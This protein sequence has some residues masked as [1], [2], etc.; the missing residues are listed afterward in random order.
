V[1]QQILYCGACQTQLR[2]SDFEK[3]GAVK[4]GLEA[5]CKACVPADRAAAL[6]ASSPKSPAPPTETPKRGSQRIPL[7][8]SRTPRPR[9]STVAVPVSRP[10][11]AALWAAAAGG[12]VVIL[13]VAVL[14]SGSSP[15]KPAPPKPGLVRVDPEPPPPPP[16]SGPTLREQKALESLKA[17]R[18]AAREDAFVKAVNDALG[19]P[20]EADARRGLEELRAERRRAADA[21]AVEAETKL[22]AVLDAEDFKRAAELAPARA[23]EFLARAELLFRPL[24]DKALDAFRRGATE[25]VDKARAR[26]AAWGLGTFAADLDRAVAEASKPPPPPPPADAPPSAEAVKA[27]RDAAFER[28]AGRVFPEALEALARLKSPEAAEDLDLLRLVA[29]AHD[30]ALKALAK[31]PKGKKLA[32]TTT[33]YDREISR[34]EATFVRVHDFHLELLRGKSPMTVQLGMT[35]PRTFAEILPAKDR[36]AVAAA[37][38]LEGDEAGALEILKDDRAP[39]P[40]RWWD[41][42]ADFRRRHAEGPLASLERDVSYRFYEAMLRFPSPARRADGALLCAKIAREHRD[43]PWVGRHLPL[44]ESRAELAREF[45]AGP[46]VLRA[47]GAFR[48]ETDR[49]RAYWMSTADGD[50]AR[51]ASV[52]EADFS[53][54]PDVAYRAWAWIGACCAETAAFTLSG[55]DFP[56]GDEAPP[57]KTGFLSSTKTH[58]GHGGKKRPERWT[59][60]ELPLPAYP[61][62][63]AKTL[64]LATNQ[65][66]F[67]VGWIVVSSTRD[68]APADAELKERD[69]ELSRGPG[70]LGPTLALQA[71]FRADAGPAAEGGRV[72]RWA[73]ASGRGRHAAPPDPAARPLYVANGLNNRPSVRFDGERS[74]LAFDC[75]AQG[76]SSMTILALVQTAKNVRGFDLGKGSVL[77]WK[78]WGP[79]GMIYLAPAQTGV[80]WRF[81]TG[82]WGNAPVWAR[83]NNEAWTAPQLVTIRKDGAREELFVQGVSVLALGDRFQPVAHTAENAILGGGSDDSRRN[84]AQ[85][86]AGDVGELLIYARALPEAERLAVEGYLRLKYGL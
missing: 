49:D 66:G 54:L 50:P 86:W 60:V 32:V 44:L 31:F 24:R 83:P 47:A 61:A 82:Q 56:G 18:A 1:G 38:L 19:T 51:R 11:S 62:P 59:W 77:Q 5:W 48:L 68:K 73:D 21:A 2:G 78:E 35:L 80:A 55:T 25:E 4:L 40:R 15:P 75:P 43:L 53:T 27:A 45:V 79:W 74:L 63:G 12:A 67:S 41:W 9:P 34:T 72:V 17:A 81:G 6:Q 22:R 85:G 20:L 36:R 64:R 37:C 57:L 28:A 69:K 39:L 46:D 58:A 23:A 70:P 3:G 7:V 42:A 84:P 10:A 29:A 26:V 30:D 71:W 52:V 65:Q 33:N 8:D 76:T 14:A 16:P 13:F